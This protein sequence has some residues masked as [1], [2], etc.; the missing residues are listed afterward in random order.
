MCLLVTQ[1]CPT[2]RPNGLAHQAPLS[3]ELNSCNYFM[4]SNIWTCFEIN[5]IV[6][7]VNIMLPPN[8]LEK[9]DAGCVVEVTFR[10]TTLNSSCVEREQCWLK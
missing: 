3:M 6:L 4:G 7:L 2:L 1:L 9:S 5:T 8:N 10:I